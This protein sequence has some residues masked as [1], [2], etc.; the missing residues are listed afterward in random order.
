MSR[1]Y[2]Y[3]CP[4]PVNLEEKFPAGLRHSSVVNK[5]AVSGIDIPAL[6]I[7]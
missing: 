6:Q 7:K 3:R 2:S 4:L 5:A 1:R